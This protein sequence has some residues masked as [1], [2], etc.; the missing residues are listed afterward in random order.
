MGVKELKNNLFS[1]SQKLIK[2]IEQKKDIFILANSTIDGI[3]S[4][5]IILKSIFNNMGNATIR[6]SCKKIKDT[7]S[8]IIDEK[9]EFYIFTDF[10]SNAIDNV[11]KSFNEGNYL[12]IN[13]DK[14]TKSDN[15]TY[16]N[17]INPW[18]FNVNGKEEISSAGLAYFLIKNFDRNFN[19]LSQLP[20]ISAISK[21]Q[22]I[23]EN[24]IIDKL[25]Q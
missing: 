13:I 20:I 21:D 6:C 7:L 5:S 4:G 23:G 17:I 2:E 15:L 16:E 1:K 18:L 19:N 10:D 25:K 22:D 11:N 3:L 9:H 14:I 8:E 12:F 24:Q